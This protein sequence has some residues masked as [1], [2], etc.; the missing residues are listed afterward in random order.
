MEE[1]IYNLDI[2]A[3]IIA[4]MAIKKESAYEDE[5]DPEEKEKLKLSVDILRAEQDA[6]YH[7]NLIQRSVIDK[8]FNFYGP[9]LKAEYAAS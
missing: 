3:E 2:A 6:L 4:R 7:D 9:I 1:N 5:K 8:A